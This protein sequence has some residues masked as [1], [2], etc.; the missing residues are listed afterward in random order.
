MIVRKLRPDE[1]LKAEILQATAFNYSY[2]AAEHRGELLD[3]EAWGAFWDD[4]ETLAS[5]MYPITYESRFGDAYIPVLGIGGVATHPQYRRAGGIRAIFRQLFSASAERGWAASYLYP[6]SFAYYRKF[7]YE[8]V[9]SRKEIR[10]G[11]EVLSRIPRNTSAVLYEDPEQLP[12]LLDVYH[13]YARQMQIIFR[14]ST[15]RSSGAYSA[16][17][18]KSL[19]Y[20]YIWRDA[21]QQA[22]AYANCRIRD[23]W[24]CVEELCYT[25][26]ESLLGILGFLRMYEGQVDGFHFTN[27]PEDTPLDF[28]M[29]NYCDVEY[30]LHSFAMGRVLL[31]EILFAAHTYPDA[32]SGAFRILVTEPDVSS[33]AAGVYDICYTGGKGSVHRLPMN[34]ADSA[35]IV[36]SVDAL[37]RIMLGGAALTPEAARYIPGIEIRNREGAAAF[38][39]AFPHRSVC[40]YTSF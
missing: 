35:D 26:P 14:R 19:K 22:Q 10:I 5:M 9:L 38:C 7:G 25:S 20:T 17:P 2:D 34:S 40:L 13:R 28:L 4:G 21:E 1:K 33:G 30:S 37:S 18:H 24:L 31:P 8:R 27:L 23:G 36:C 12:V 39:R 29:D 6:F 3:T 32:V 16:N 15:E 11:C